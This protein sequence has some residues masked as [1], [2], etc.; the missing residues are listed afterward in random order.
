MVFQVNMLNTSL[1]KLFSQPVAGLLFFTLA[2]TNFL[3]AVMAQTQTP[4]V[5]QC[6]DQELADSRNTQASYTGYT[7]GGGDRI[8]VNVF[9]VEEYTGEYTIPPGGAINLALIGT[10]PV[11]GL[12]T[13]QAANVIECAYRTYL[14]RPI[15][16][17]NLLS[18]RPI[19][20][21]VAGEVSRPGAYSLSLSGGAGQDPGVQYATVMSALTTAQGVTQAADITQVQLRRRLG[22][23]PEQV[24]TLDLKKYIQTGTLP[25]DVTLRDGDTIFVPTATGLNL[26][27]ARNLSAA[28]FAADITQPRSVVVT[29][30]VNRPGTYLVTQGQAEGVGTGTTTGTNAPAISGQPTV[31]RAIQLAG[32]ITPQANIRDIVIRRPTR[33]GTEQQ[34]RVNFW[35]LLQ[36]GDINQDIVVQDGDTI[37]IPTATEV[38]PAEA[39]QLANTTLS[40]SRIQVGVVG[41]VK[42]PGR[43]EVLPNSTLNQAVLAAGG[44]NNARARSSTVDLIRLNPDGSVTKRRVKINFSAGINEKTNPILRNNDVIV[45]N[46]SNAALTGDSIGAIFNPIGTVLGIIRSVLTGF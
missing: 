1:W 39:T 23:G 45:V 41:E 32:G 20:V 36:S 28:S 4:T 44:F 16:S 22:Y 37:V 13:E 7:L 5:K 19:N 10:V 29:G 17:V 11:Q 38:N 31:S 35:Q 6:L 27:D 3:P 14:K 43:V 34:I 18:P 42:N 24:I 2:L 26:A 15:I 12:S 21:T 25:Q 40:P 30:E 33:T 46:R 9:E 8:R